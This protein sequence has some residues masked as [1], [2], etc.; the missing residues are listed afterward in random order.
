MSGWLL[1]WGWATAAQAA[2]ENAISSIDVARAISVSEVSFIEEKADEFRASRETIQA[3]IPCLS[4]PMSSAQVVSLY[5]MEA[6]HAFLNED[7]AGTRAAFRGLLTTSPSYSL[8]E[9]IAPFDHPLQVTF[10]AVMSDPSGEVTAIRAPRSG[11]VWVDGVEEA[12]AVPTDR[13]YLFQYVGE[14]GD[15]AI[16]AYMQPGDELPRYGRGGGR[17]DLRAPLLV[18][19]GA[20]AV[21]AGGTLWWGIRREAAFKD[22]QTPQE[23]LDAIRR[24]TNALG[25]ISLGAGL[26]AAGSGAAAIIVAPW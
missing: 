3:W 10:E 8:S 1:L 16:S 2:C 23:D 9:S 11:A 24:Q 15:V 20:A 25:A 19:A 5:K 4:T 13:P 26:V 17:R 22:P 6:L 12:E 21:V 14:A 18:T 7:E